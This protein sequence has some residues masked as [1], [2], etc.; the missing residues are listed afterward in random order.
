MKNEQSEWVGINKL[1]VYNPFMFEIARHVM[2]L[3]KTDVTNKTGI[4]VKN[5]TSIEMG[6]RNPTDKELNSLVLFYGFPIFFFEQWY[7][8]RLDISGVLAKNVPIDYLKYKI[9]KELN[10]NFNRMK[11]YFPI[12]QAKIIN[13]KK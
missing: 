3:S 12:P 13:F 6:E 11:A 9:F 2:G 5:I 4:L 10:P 8:T 7:D 1:P